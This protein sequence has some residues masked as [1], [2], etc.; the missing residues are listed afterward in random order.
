MTGY[1][2]PKSKYSNFL[3]K[4]VMELCREKNMT[5]EEIAN[6]IGMSRS[7]FYQYLSGKFE[8][9]AATVYTFAKYFGVSA[10]YLMGITSTREDNVDLREIGDRLK[11]SDE[12]LETFLA[13]TDES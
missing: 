1:I 4:R 13:L 11:L 8:P 2:E 10:D 6:E 3:G 5:I 9:K 12:A 7:S